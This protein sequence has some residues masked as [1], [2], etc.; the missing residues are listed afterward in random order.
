PALSDFH[1]ILGV[2][3][4]LRMID[5][6]REEAGRS[7]VHHRHQSG[8]YRDTSQ[9][10]RRTQLG[11]ATISLLASSGALESITGDRRAALWHA[12]AVEKSGKEPSLFS[13]SDADDDETLTT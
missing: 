12:L 7:I 1:S 13:F 11:Q 9:L 2:R 5:R 6:L 4:G 8:D 10:V 3:L